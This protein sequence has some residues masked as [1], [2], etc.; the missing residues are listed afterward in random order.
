MA[1]SQRP[2]AHPIQKNSIQHRRQKKL[3][4]YDLSALSELLSDPELKTPR[5]PEPQPVKVSPTS[6]QKILLREVQQFAAVLNNPLFQSDPKSAIHQHLR[7]TLPIVEEQP[8]K[9]V[10]TNGSK[11]KNKK[12]SKASSSGVISMDT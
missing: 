3:K 8:K 5:K 10:N 1:T 11:K 2:V 7:N 12:K 4:A 6:R 9:K